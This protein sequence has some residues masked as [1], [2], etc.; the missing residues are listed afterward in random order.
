MFTLSAR[1]DYG[2]IFLK[3]LSA[4]PPGHYA[5]VRAIAESQKLPLK[6]LERV[7]AALVSAGIVVSREGQGGGYALA[8]PVTQVQLADVL[9]VLEGTLEPVTC[10]HDGT[11]CE[12]EAACER[13]TG[14]QN[15]HSKLYQVLAQHTL[16][17]I[18]S[19]I[20]N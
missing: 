13:K 2:L 8:K 7:A 5:T 11:C 3:Y 14:W 20:K 15:V 17:D 18:L 19:T 6:Y 4:L 12:R 16:A 10:T 9:E 1:G